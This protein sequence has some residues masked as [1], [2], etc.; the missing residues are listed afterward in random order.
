MAIQFSLK[1]IEYFFMYCNHLHL[2][3]LP[4]SC[5]ISYLYSSYNL[6]TLIA[7]RCFY[8]LTKDKAVNRPYFPS[9]FISMYSI[10]KITWNIRNVI[11]RYVTTKIPLSNKLFIG[12]DVVLILTIIN[13]TSYFISKRFEMEILWMY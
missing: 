7:N 12:I 11:K 4:L 13:K 8:G 5:V 9:E 6:L 3:I 2:F 10:Q 1:K